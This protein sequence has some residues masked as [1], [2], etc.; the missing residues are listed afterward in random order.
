MDQI[1]KTFTT[2]KRT[3]VTQSDKIIKNIID[4]YWDIVFQ[5]LGQ[6]SHGQ[7]PHN[8]GTKKEGTDWIVDPLQNS[9]GKWI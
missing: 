2:Q 4:Q 8:Q 5:N 7:T 9:V 3:D 1:R 6:I